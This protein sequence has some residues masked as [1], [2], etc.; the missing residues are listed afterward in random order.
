MFSDACG[1]QNRNHTLVAFFLALVAIGRFKKIYQ[2]FPVRGHSFLQCDRNFGVAKRKIRKLDRI[3]TP[4]QYADLIKTSRK[5]S[6]FNVTQVSSE[7][8]L[9]FKD[10]STKNFKKTV[11]SRDGVPF[12]ISKCKQL[13]YT[14]PAGYVKAYEYINGLTSSTFLVQKPHTVI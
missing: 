6:G 10:W 9:D 2:Y 7:N 8:I 11:K 12:L 3:Y 13:E 14:L 1:G 4:E 5:T